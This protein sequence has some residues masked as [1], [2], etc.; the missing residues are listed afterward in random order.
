MHANVLLKKKVAHLCRFGG[1]LGGEDRG[2]CYCCC[3]REC[4]LGLVGGNRY[5]FS[6]VLK[7]VIYNSTHRYVCCYD[8]CRGRHA[9]GRDARSLL[10][11]KNE[12]IASVSVFDE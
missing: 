6:N 12:K 7:K 9:R 1:M 11:G 10:S 4:L 3:C 2:G 8:R 5:Y